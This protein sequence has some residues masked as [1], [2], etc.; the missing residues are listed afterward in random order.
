MLCTNRLYGANITT[1][2]ILRAESLITVVTKSRWLVGI[3]SSEITHNLRFTHNFRQIPENGVP[4]VFVIPEKLQLNSTEGRKHAN[5]PIS[6]SQRSEISSPDDCQSSVIGMLHTVQLF[7]HIKHG[8]IR[9]EEWIGTIN[10]ALT[11]N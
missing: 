4:N 3:D 10:F 7:I 11:N 2:T 6:V 1:D 8:D 9:S 5:S